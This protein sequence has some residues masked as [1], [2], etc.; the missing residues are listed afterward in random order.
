MTAAAALRLTVASSVCTANEG[1]IIISTNDAPLTWGHISFYF[2]T[3][4]AFDSDVA[5]MRVLS[6][7]K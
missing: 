6:T 7:V 3:I 2:F 4:K 1:M 5:E